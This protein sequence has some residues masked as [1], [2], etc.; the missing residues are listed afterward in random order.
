M[1]RQI[2]NAPRNIPGN[3]CP[4]ICNTGVITMSYNMH[5]Y[6]LGIGIKYFRRSSVEEKKYWK[7]P[8]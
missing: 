4:V 7:T 6:F 5:V 1:P 8:P 2:Q 3:F